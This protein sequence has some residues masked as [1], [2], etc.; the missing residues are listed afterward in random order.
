L[1]ALNAQNM[2]G[3]IGLICCFKTRKNTLVFSV[4][5]YAKNDLAPKQNHKRH[6]IICLKNMHTISGIKWEIKNTHKSIATKLYFPQ[7]KSSFCEA[8]KTLQP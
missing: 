4:K 6:S 7:Q 2:N 3:L 1:W 8:V 5:S